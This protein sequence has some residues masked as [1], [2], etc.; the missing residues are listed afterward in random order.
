MDDHSEAWIVITIY[1]DT[2]ANADVDDDYDVDD[3][4]DHDEDD[5]QRVVA[6]KVQM[7]EVVA[8]LLSA[9]WPAD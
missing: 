4:G 3:D 1:A 2:D 8:T 9:N 5:D 6:V 7:V